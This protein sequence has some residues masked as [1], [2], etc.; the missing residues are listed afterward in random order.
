MREITLSGS[1]Y[2]MGRQ[3]GSMV[4]VKIR[5][6]LFMTRLMA[7]AS[8]GGGRDFF[9]PKYRHMLVGLFRM[10]AYQRRYRKVAEEF[11]AAIVRY[12]PATL[13]LI[14]GIADSVRV[15]Y[16]DVIFMNC[17]LE[18]SL[19]CSAFAATGSATREGKPLIAMNADESKAVQPYYMVIHFKPDEGFAFTAVYMTGT[20]F[21]VFGMNEAGLALASLGLFLNN[22]AIDKIR[23]PFFLKLSVIHRCATV[24]EAKAVFDRIPASGMG[25]ATYVADAERLLV[26]EESVLAK[27]SKIYENGFHYTGNYPMF[28]GLEQYV[29]IDEFDDIV[30]FFAKNR[31]RRIGEFLAAQD[32]VLDEEQFHQ[33]LSDH[34]SKEDDS[35]NKSVCV[36]PENSNGIQTCASIVL[37]PADKSMTVCEGNPCRDRAT[38]F[39]A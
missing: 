2:E 7:V 21:P 3:Y 26:Q 31:H 36:H 27:S 17:L 29:K 28:A 38:T 15:D 4:K 6:F 24:E 23:L 1:F 8:E 19:K 16:R 10:R 37:S 33:M 30:F 5:L 11:E 12:D 25:A 20:I 32:G 35:V 13:E 18:Y 39:S 22:D 9:R 14:K 34:G